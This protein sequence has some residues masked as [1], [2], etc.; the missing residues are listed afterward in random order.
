VTGGWRKL[1]NNKLH[2]FYLH[3]IKEDEMDWACR[4]QGGGGG[5]ENL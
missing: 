1:N 4:E 5:N 3:Q 2:N